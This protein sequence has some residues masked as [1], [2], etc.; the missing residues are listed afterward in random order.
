MAAL[1]QPPAACTA[2]VDAPRRTSSLD[3]AAASG[4][5]RDALEAE[6]GG[7]DLQAAVDLVRADGTTQLGRGGRRR[8]D[9]RGPACRP[10]V[11][12]SSSRVAG[13]VTIGSGAPSAPGGC[14]RWRLRLAR[15]PRH[16]PKA[17]RVGSAPGVERPPQLAG[18]SGLRRR[19]SGPRSHV[20]PHGRARIS[21]SGRPFRGR[22]GFHVDRLGVDGLGEHL[23]ATCA[24]GSAAIPS[25]SSIR[26]PGGGDRASA[27]SSGVRL[28]PTT[29]T[30]ARPPA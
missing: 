19:W 21:G 9:E 18:D 2:V 14:V 17:I 6:H 12:G 16:G 5:G 26:M 3:Q 27:F 30:S 22:R 15:R 28:R 8:H 29:S 25:T 24:S 23:V 11:A 4:V 13:A 7:Q 10:V 1:R 20:P